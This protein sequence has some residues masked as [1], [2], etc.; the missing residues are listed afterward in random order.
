MKVL[1]PKTDT[2][3]IKVIPRNYILTTSVELRDDQTNES[4]TYTPTVVK[5]NDYLVY[6]DS[7]TL[8][9]GH[10]Y[11]FLVQNDFDR[12]DQNT[13][14]FNLSDNTWNDL[15]FRIEKNVVDKIFCTEQEIDQAEQ[16]EYTINKGIYKS[17]TSF[18]KEYI[19][20]E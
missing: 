2:Q 9:E 3:S 5:D 7:Y 20:Y 13:D 19:I 8:V 16:K 12:W 1:K 10:F 14:F 15:N 11:D 17:D 18:D 6:S 4:I